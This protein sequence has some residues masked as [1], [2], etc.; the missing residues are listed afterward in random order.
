MNLLVK[1]LQK[2][3]F[4]AGNS[5]QPS[6]E[7]GQSAFGSGHTLQNDVAYDTEYPNSFLD[8]YRC[9]GEAAATV[10]FIHGGGYTWGDKMGGDPNA[11]ARENLEGYFEYFLDA[12]YDVV[13][14][15]YALAPEHQ[16]PVPVIQLT[17]AL[18]FLRENGNSLGIGTDR[19]VL[20]GGSAGAQLAGQL[21]CLQLN[22]ALSERM[23][24]APVLRKEQIKAAVLNSSLLDCARF[25]DVGDPLWGMLFHR[26]G[27]AYF[28]TRKYPSDPRMAETD[29]IE[30]MTADWPP[31]YI[32][33]GNKATFT[34]QAKELARRAG[35]L[36]VPFT[37]NLY[38]RETATLPHGYE[39]GDSPQAEDN[40]ARQLAF[41]Q[42][43][44]SGQGTESAG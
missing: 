43:A 28:G 2:K 18:R 9:K 40:R 20:C 32:S 8:I 30:N 5:Y 34:E 3:M 21:V 27:T 42:S 4:L 14:A 12:G 15:N 38:D 22:P 10:F 35:E 37:L 23:G 26:C 25:R 44:L 36:G 1:L 33:D 16:Y 24:I 6:K 13:S 7:P 29:V 31:V 41:L 39:T 19:L 17:R 11:S